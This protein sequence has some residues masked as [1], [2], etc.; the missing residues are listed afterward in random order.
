MYDPIYKEAA[1]FQIKCV[2]TAKKFLHDAKAYLLC[3][4]SQV[5]SAE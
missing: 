1:V 2:I 3:T 5:A 4:S